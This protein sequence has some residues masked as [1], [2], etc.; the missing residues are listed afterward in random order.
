MVPLGLLASAIVL[1]LAA[2]R[3]RFLF[4]WAVFS[5]PYL[6]YEFLLGWNVDVGVY[7]VYVAPALTAL[8][9]V[10]VTSLVSL[11]RRA[12]AGAGTRRVAK[13]IHSWW[14]EPVFATFAAAALVDPAARSARL[15]E[16][17][18]S[19]NAFSRTELMRTCAS[20]R[21]HAPPGSVLVQPPGLEHVNF[22]PC[23]TGLRPI[24]FQGG[25]F[26]IFVGERSTPLNLDAFPVLR[27]AY[28][29]RLLER[30]IP[31]LSLVP[32]PFRWTD[33][34]D[35][36]AGRHYRWTEKTMLP[37]EGEE[38]PRTLYVLEWAVDR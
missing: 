10:A 16:K 22:M 12:S 3:N 15:A 11:A 21:R 18:V 5:S 27:P 25:L 28:L 23:H 24:I 9:A 4:F 26:R 19:R 36:M 30:G 34:D 38:L 33:G 31:V 1:L 2:R 14:L 29:D 35:A 20:V 32:D 6:A 17:V 13:S 37:A 8:L 7:M